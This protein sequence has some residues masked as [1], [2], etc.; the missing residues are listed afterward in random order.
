MEKPGK[1]RSRRLH[2]LCALATTAAA[3]GGNTVGGLEHRSD[4]ETT[5]GS[6]SEARD[7]RTVDEHALDVCPDAV[8]PA[9]P[10]EA[11]E[12]WSRAL[13]SGGVSLEG[14]PAESCGSPDGDEGTAAE[15]IRLAFQFLEG[16]GYRG[17]VGTGASCYRVDGVLH[18]YQFFVDAGAADVDLYVYSNDGFASEPICVNQDN[19][20]MSVHCTT[21]PREG[22]AIESAVRYLVIDGSKTAGATP[23]EIS[24]SG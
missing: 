7:S 13:D 19:A 5:V 14:L 21:Y 3:C 12:N 10:S 18:G 20:P 15:P 1:P 9:P 2:W 4:A 17:S 11:D 22:P 6:A 16:E 23:I 24:V 8:L